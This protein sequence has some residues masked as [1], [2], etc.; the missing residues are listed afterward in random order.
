MIS[1]EAANY[2]SLMAIITAIHEKVCV[3][4]TGLKFPGGFRQSSETNDI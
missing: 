3:V 4:V 1:F 2:P